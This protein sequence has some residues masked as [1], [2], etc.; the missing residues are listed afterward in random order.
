MENVQE[1]GDGMQVHSTGIS[2]WGTKGSH[3]VCSFCEHRYRW[4]AAVVECH[5]DPTINKSS[6]DKE[7][8]VKVC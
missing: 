1:M 8:T 2:T 7:R 5:M 3:P 4:L 6:T